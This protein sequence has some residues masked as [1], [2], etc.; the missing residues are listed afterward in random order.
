MEP[1]KTDD[2]GGLNRIFGTSAGE[3][4]AAVKRIVCR[5]DP[6]KAWAM[7]MGG[8]LKMAIQTVFEMVFQWYTYVYVYIYIYVYIND[9]SMVLR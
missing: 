5:D 7:R 3:A 8:P 9:V 4:P 2:S 1:P 6:K